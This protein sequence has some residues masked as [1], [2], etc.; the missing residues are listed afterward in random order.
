MATIL[1]YVYWRGDLSLTQDPWRAADSAVLA[2]LCYLNP[3]EKGRSDE[4]LSLREFALSLPEK[5]SGSL[6]EGRRTLCILAAGSRR[7]GDIR[8]SR[9][10]YNVNPEAGIQFAAFCAQ[11]PDGV[12]A[13]CFRGTDA[14]LV[15]WREDFELSYSSP[16]PAQ[17]AAVDYLRDAPGGRLILL[18]HSKGGNLAAYAASHVPT[19][20]QARIEGIWSF[21]GPGLDE[22][23]AASPGYAAVSGKIH[24]LIPQSSIIGLLMD[25][26]PVYTIVR[27]EGASLMQH[28]LHTWQMDGP[29]FAVLQDTTFSSQLMDRALHDWMRQAAPEQRQLFVESVFKVLQASGAVSVSDFRS[30]ELPQVARMA[31]AAAELEPETRKLVMQLFAGFFTAGASSAFAIGRDLLGINW[32]G[33]FLAKLNGG[34]EDG[35]MEG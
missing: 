3:P 4:G 32:A 22:E 13:V 6:Y 1:D 11:L 21:D 23:T 12:T 26:H 28:N 17:T 24:S 29:D 18:G 19:D 9:F 35:R 27:A 15:G 16:V 7:F 8:I 30:L 2:S 5:G 14:T 10:V 25:Y 33:P 34:S 31:K 20:V